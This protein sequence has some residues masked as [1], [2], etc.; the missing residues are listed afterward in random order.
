MADAIE[1]SDIV[2][3][4][5]SPEEITP[6]MARLPLE[7]YTLDVSVTNRSETALSVISEIRNLRY[8]A[9]RRLLVVEL[10]ERELTEPRRLEPVN[11][12]SWVV[13]E[14]SE[15]TTLTIRLLSPITWLEETP[16]GERQ[17]LHVSLTEDIDAIECIVGYSEARPPAAFDPTAFEPPPPRSWAVARGMTSPV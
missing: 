9:E 12:P 15:R 5:L 17:P 2:L 13:V 14:P 7:W 6:T 11:P 1:I 10:S 4:P 8:E 16:A 3:S